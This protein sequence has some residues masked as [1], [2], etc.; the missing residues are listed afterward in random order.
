MLGEALAGKTVL[1]RGLK[2]VKDMLL[3]LDSEQGSVIYTKLIR[4]PSQTLHG[5]TLGASQIFRQISASQS[6]TVTELAID[7]TLSLLCDEM[8]Y[9][10]SF[11][12][13]ANGCRP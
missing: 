13:L 4:S 1:T 6:T 9:L 10:I 12:Q 2:S 3:E 5:T 7:E 11:G 8:R